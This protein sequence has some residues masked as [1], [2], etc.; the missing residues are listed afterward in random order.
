MYFRALYVF[1]S[2]ANVSKLKQTLY[3][4]DI[5]LFVFFLSLVIL[6]LC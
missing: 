3:I 4:F 6:F 5:Q 2:S 1:N